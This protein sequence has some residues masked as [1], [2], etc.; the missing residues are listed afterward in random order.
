MSGISIAVS[1]END[2]GV[3]SPTDPVSMGN[4]FFVSITST[5]VLGMHPALSGVNSSTYI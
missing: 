2:L 4:F 3:G 5:W 1:A